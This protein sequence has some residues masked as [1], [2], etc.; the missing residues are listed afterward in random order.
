MPDPSVRNLTVPAERIERW[1]N[2]FA[3]RHGPTEWQATPSDVVVTAADGAIAKCKVPFPPLTVDDEVAYGGLVQHVL[4]DRSVGILLVRR[5]GFAAGVF[6]GRTLTTS[7]VGSRHV[8]GRTAAGGQ[9]QQRFARRRDKQ[10]REAFEAAADVAARILAPAADALDAVCVGGDRAALDQVLTDPRLV[11]V[12][13]LVVPP[14]L[15]V[16]NP[17]RAVLETT[18]NQ[19]RAVTIALTE[20]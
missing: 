10:A 3:D 17:K 20:P 11:A 6:D 19:F 14:H 7:K 1:L 9:S 13:A 4:R 16:P 2:G 12:R 18:P 8:Q 5:G 15:N